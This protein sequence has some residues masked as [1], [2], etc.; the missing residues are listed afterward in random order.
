[1]IIEDD[2]RFNKREYQRAYNKSDKGKSVRQ[3]YRHRNSKHTT[4]AHYLSRQIVAIDGEGINIDTGEHLYTLL[5]IS[6]VKPLYDANGIKTADAL[7]YLYD[8][9]S[10]D[11]INVI[12]GGS[13]D[14]NCWLADLI[15]QDLAYVYRSSYTT[16]PLYYEG[17]GIRWIKGKAFEIHGERGTVTINDVI[18][19][20]QRPFIQACDEYLGPDWEGREIIVREKARRGNFTAEEIANVAAY[21][22]LELDRLIDLVT[23]LRSRLNKVG[24]RPR[25]WNSP[26]AIASALFQREGVKAHR[27]E[28]IP[29]AVA[30]AGRY[31]YAGGRF[32]MIKYGA[33]KEFVYEYDINSAYPRALLEVPSL[34]NGKW[35]HREKFAGV[36]PE[37]ALF[38][39]RFHGSNPYIPAPIFVRSDKGTITYPLEAENWVWS[40]EMQVLTEYCEQIPDT[41]YEVLEVWEYIPAT[42]VK[43]F[44]FIS[45]LYKMRQAL[46]KAKDGAHVGIKLALNSLYGKLA[47][48]VGWIPASKT[49]PMRVPS[50]HQLEWAGYVTSWCRANVLRAA[51][52]DIDSV[53]AFETDALFTSRP[54]K[55]QIGSGLGEWEETVFTSLSY[56]Q[57][58]HYYGTKLNDDG[59]TEEVVKCRGI[60]KGFISRERVEG[61]LANVES[62]RTLDAELTRFYG[63]GIA[64]A[65]GFDK[66]LWRRWLTEPKRLN[67]MPTGKRVH[68]FCCDHSAP[69]ELGRWHQTVCPSSGGVSHPY[70]VEWINPDENMTELSELRESEKFYE[71]A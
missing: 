55:V 46:K 13:Y 23:E 41:S 3:S 40:P 37:F 54:L 14:F 19:F 6:G 12:Y 17:Y 39:V 50:Y 24:L 1:M 45:A 30:E 53:V 10:A 35:V 28:A 16:N 32:E 71:S 36:I 38:R 57:S 51:L 18:S 21:N 31:A 43:P 20:F 34:A 61:Q 25:R 7:R 66:G 5:A 9:L 44:A 70:P 4:D 11:N 60:D 48:Q 56:V 68:A 49:R 64:L 29:E 59:T 63:A 62:E 58:G 15:E 65:R 67:L 22:S 2:S 8:N 47:Q 52:V 33:V 42:D 26:G 69:L 27:N